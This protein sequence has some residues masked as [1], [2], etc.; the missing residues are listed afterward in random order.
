MLPYPD[1]DYKDISWVCDFCPIEYDYCPKDA[2]MVL[3]EVA[4]GNLDLFNFLK[5]G[6]V[7]NSRKS[8]CEHRFDCEVECIGANRDLFVCH[9]GYYSIL[10]GKEELIASLSDPLPHY[11]PASLE[12]FYNNILDYFFAERVVVNEFCIPREKNHIESVMKDEVD[13]VLE[14]QYRARKAKWLIC[15]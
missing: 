8:M 7:Y 9:A 5:K 1:E 4:G 13:V 10:D 12:F 6:Y 3:A 14:C 15:V 2:C 11:V